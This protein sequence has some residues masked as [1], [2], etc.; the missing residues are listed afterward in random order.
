LLALAPGIDG[1][2]MAGSFPNS[3]TGETNLLSAS[4]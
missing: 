1:A 3:T 4:L 2:P